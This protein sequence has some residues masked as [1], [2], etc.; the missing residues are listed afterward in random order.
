MVGSIGPDLYGAED[1]ELLVLLGGLILPQIAEFLRASEQQ[2]LATDPSPATGAS[3]LLLKIAGALATM[4]DAAAATRLIA[5]EGAGIV[6]FERMTF[7]L[8]L[9]DS[10]RVV[11]L[12]P[13]GRSAVL[14][15]GAE[16]ACGIR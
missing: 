9:T 15:P 10:D 8:K 16:M 1:V 11:V 2:A 14:V 3:E 7:A 4:T 6:P 5:L 13:G 12:Q